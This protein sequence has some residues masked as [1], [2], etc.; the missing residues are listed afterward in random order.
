MEEFAGKTERCHWL[1]WQPKAKVLA[2]MREARVLV[3]PSECYE[4]FGLVVAEVYAAGLPVIGSRHGS[5]GA[6]IDGVPVFT[7]V[8]ETPTIW[9]ARS[10]GRSC[11][12]VSWR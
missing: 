9:P 6:I 1:R 4:T 7:S 2:L 12:R 3:V 5:I 11:T 10:S 8:L